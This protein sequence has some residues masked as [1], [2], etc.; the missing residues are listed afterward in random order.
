MAGTTPFEALLGHKPDVSH[1][2]FFGSKAWAIIPMD[3]R[4]DFQ[5]QSSECILLGYAENAKEY[6]L[7]ELATR[8]C[9]IERNVQFEEDQLLDPPQFE[10]KGGINTLP[11][12]FDDDILS[13][14]S[15]S[16]DKEQYQHDINIEVVP[17]ENLNPAPTPIQ[18]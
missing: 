17:H 3:K 10:A 5:A 12:P 7:M 8:K 16:D 15:D 13:H 14:V 1:L 9:F 18:N 6:K 4:K 2:I 11:F